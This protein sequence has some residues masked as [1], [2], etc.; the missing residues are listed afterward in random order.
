MKPT[1]KDPL[2][3][4]ELKDSENEID[5]DNESEELDDF[6]ELVWSDFSER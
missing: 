5:L 6:R 3:K 4:E 1:I 2:P